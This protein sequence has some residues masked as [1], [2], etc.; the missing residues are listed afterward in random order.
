[1]KEVKLVV[2]LELAEK[3]NQVGV[4]KNPAA[5]RMVPL[6]EKEVSPEKGLT[7]MVCLSMSLWPLGIQLDKSVSQLF[8]GCLKE[9]KV[10]V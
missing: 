9:E 1:L 4:W 3:V 7:L 6:V 2:K 10:E 5:E 8:D